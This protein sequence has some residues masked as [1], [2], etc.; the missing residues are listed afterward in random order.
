MLKRQRFLLPPA[1]SAGLSSHHGRGKLLI[2]LIP[3]PLHFTP[4]AGALFLTTTANCTRFP[5]PYPA[6][7]CRSI[8][9]MGDWRILGSWWPLSWLPHRMEV[10]CL[11]QT[12]ITEG[13]HP[14]PC[15]ITKQDVTLEKPISIPSSRKVTSDFC[16]RGRV[17][18]SG[19]RVSQLCLYRV[20]LFGIK[21]ELHS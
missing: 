16:T 13:C 19:Q 10:P 1:P 14:L 17:K 12:N 4:I 9:G 8:P 18:P 2:V 20:P 21:P 6:P 11:G 5:L 15:L 7:T 3:H